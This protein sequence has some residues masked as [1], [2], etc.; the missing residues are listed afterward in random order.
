[1]DISGVSRS[2]EPVAAT[3]PVFPTEKAAEHREVVQAVKAL[4][5]QVNPQFGALDFTQ[6]QIVPAP[7]TVTRAQGPVKAAS[8]SATAPA[9]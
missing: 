6:Y 8:S 5:I 1:M 9:C 7:V 2:L 3:M 4:N